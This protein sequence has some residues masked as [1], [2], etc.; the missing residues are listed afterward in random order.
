VPAGSRMTKRLVTDRD[1]CYNER[2]IPAVCITG[3]D[4]LTTGVDY[5]R[6]GQPDCLIHEAYILKK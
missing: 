6:S 3:I 4:Q 1:E 5:I 2:N